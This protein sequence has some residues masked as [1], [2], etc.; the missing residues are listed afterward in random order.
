V[1]FVIETLGAAEAI[2]SRIV[3]YAA[4]TD[5]IGLSEVLRRASSAARGITDPVALTEFIQ[6]LVVLYRGAVDALGL[7]ESIAYVAFVPP[8]PA[9]MHNEVTPI[10][11]LIIHVEVATQESEN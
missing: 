10:A 5:G 1:R 2:S 3:K 11:T 6:R 9:H 4:T 7:S 8:I